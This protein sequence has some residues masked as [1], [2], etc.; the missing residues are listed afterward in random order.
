MPGQETRVAMGLRRAHVRV[1]VAKVGE[2]AQALVVELG[3]RR[4][5]A[6]AF[7]GRQRVRVLSDPHHH[8]DGADQRRAD[9]GFD[10][11]VAVA[12]AGPPK[13]A[14][15]KEGNGG[16]IDRDLQGHVVGKCACRAGAEHDAA[17][18]GRRHAGDPDIG[19]RSGRARRI[20]HPDPA[21]R[22]RPG[23]ETSIGARAVVDLQFDIHRHLPLKPTSEAVPCDHSPSTFYHNLS[24]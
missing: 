21:R 10:P 9:A 1:H 13:P 3:E 12:D 22:G 14:G 11:D 7:G 2:A 24:G 5:E 20:G 15:G 16:A 19:G 23:E 6:I 18:G 4:H 17:A 8:L